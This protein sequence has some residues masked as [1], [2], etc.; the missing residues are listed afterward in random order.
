MKLKKE[1]IENLVREALQEVGLYHSPT[2]GR[3]VSRGKG[4]VKS[5]TR[6]GAKAAG[7]DPKHVGRGVVT[8]KDKV[9]AKMGANFGKD[10]CGRL[11]MDGDP[12][13]PKYKCSD[14]KKKYDESLS[15]DGLDGLK[16]AGTVNLESLVKALKQIESEILEAPDPCYAQRTTWMRNLLKTL[17]SIALASDGD[18]M[19]K[20]E[21]TEER[22][23]HA[24]SHYAGS[25]IENDGKRMTDSRKKSART[26]KMR[27]RTGLTVEPFSRGEKE[28]MSTNSL[29]EWCV[30]K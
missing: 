21:A 6:K 23:K 28:L 24:N 30:T 22:P 16:S 19:P 25:P 14:Y 15:L 17:N 20:K 1:D 9:S 18:L 13:D 2:T 8:S 4:A 29:W 27:S 26:K 3:W 10:Q 7:V 12:I 5:L 11:N